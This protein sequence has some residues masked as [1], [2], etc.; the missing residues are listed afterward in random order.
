MKVTPSNSDTATDS[1]EEEYWREKIERFRKAT[2]ERLARDTME[3]AWLKK[4][5][6]KNVK[7]K[8]QKSTNTTE[9][10]ARMQ[11]EESGSMKRTVDMSE[12][13]RNLEL[14]KP[15]AEG[16]QITGRKRSSPKSDA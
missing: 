8:K 6:V 13:R 5:R 15:G 2:R 1:D 9:E 12:V 4:L 7:T 16:N 3:K 10:Q 14:W 11:V